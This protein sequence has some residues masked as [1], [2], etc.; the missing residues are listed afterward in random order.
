MDDFLALDFGVVHDL[1]TWLRAAMF[2]AAQKSLTV[3]NKS[4]SSRSE[5][6]RE[7]Y[8]GLVQPPLGL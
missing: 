7:T 3:T 4:A 1:M 8:Q 5:E 6:S 2:L